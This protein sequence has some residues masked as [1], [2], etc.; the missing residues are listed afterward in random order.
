MVDLGH[1][2][3]K[4]AL[5]VPDD[6]WTASSRFPRPRS[7][8]TLGPGARAVNSLSTVVCPATQ[9]CGNAMPCMAGTHTQTTCSVPHAGE[10]PCQ[11]GDVSSGRDEFH[12]CRHCPRS[13]FASVSCVHAFAI[14]I[15]MGFSKCSIFQH[16]ESVSHYAPY[17]FPIV[18][19][20]A[21]VRSIT[22]SSVVTKKPTK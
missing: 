10:S 17:L 19:R 3:P 5:Y 1:N 18:Q 11:C 12:N 21:T 4:M 13:D 9:K 14:W 20:R 8:Q 6:P 2:L 15:A 22:T 16:Q 7:G